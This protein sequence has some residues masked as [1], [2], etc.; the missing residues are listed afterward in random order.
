MKQ[1][2]P[3]LSVSVLFREVFPKH[4]F[5]VSGSLDTTFDWVRVITSE[6]EITERV[7]SGEL[8]L[9]AP[10]VYENDAD[11]NRTITQVVARL[12]QLRVR[13]FCVMGVVSV[14][15]LEDALRTGM[16]VICLPKNAAMETVERLALR[17]LTEQQSRVEKYEKEL[18]QAISVPGSSYQ[19][20][21]SLVAILANLI[22][23]PI[24]LHDIHYMRLT[25]AFPK[26]LV[27][28]LVRWREHLVLLEN[29]RPSGQLSPNHQWGI[30]VMENDDILQIS[31]ASETETLG[32][33]SI[34][35]SA[36]QL[37]ELAPMI[38]K[39]AAQLCGQLLNKYYVSAFNDERADNWIT[40]WLNTSPPNDM[41]ISAHAEQLGFKT[42]QTY[43]VM[44]LRWQSGAISMR[45]PITIDQFTSFVSNDTQTR[46]INAIVGQYMD[47]IVLFL[48]LEQ[49]QHTGRMKQYATTICNNLAEHFGGIVVGGVGRPAEG[50]SNL[51]QSFDEAERAHILAMQ[52]W[53]STQTKFFGDLRLSELILSIGDVDRIERFCQDW[54]HSILSY[55]Q[56]SRSDLLM[57]MAA[58]FENNGNMA[59]TAKQLNVHR[60]TLVYRLN[61]IA[62]IT[63]LDMD[64]ADVQ[65]NLHMAIKAY[66]L[67]SIMGLAG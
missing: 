59:A 40:E 45:R 1:S 41:L 58:Y 23:R 17:L 16:T 47:R 28:P 38:L 49:A 62:E 65:L 51:R 37:D 57:T 33:L 61:R 48:P 30:D 31:I 39:R 63:Q 15:A 27:P 67:L 36:A 2:M 11:P 7:S 13:A 10:Q 44:V 52:L 50:L 43:V 55:D 53:N 35:K 21:V 54:L 4:S 25:H 9:I 20:L 42:E 3:S 34:V 8:V 19:N 5:L 66:E 64:D 56:E 32:Y 12:I 14:V 46:R 24:V 60:N 22:E 18:Q 26:N 29:D 6:T